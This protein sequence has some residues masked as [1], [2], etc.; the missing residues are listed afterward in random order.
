MCQTP[1]KE[2][3]DMEAP[4]L[5]LMMSTLEKNLWRRNYGARA[6]IAVPPVA[7][8]GSNDAWEIHD[9][10]FFLQPHGISR[11]DGITRM[12]IKCFIK[13]PV[14]KTE[15]SI[16]HFGT[17]QNGNPALAFKCTLVYPR[18]C[19]SSTE[20]YRCIITTTMCIF[21]KKPSINIIAQL[22]HAHE[23]NTTGAS[24]THVVQ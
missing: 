10:Y 14:A 6:V 4:T 5:W 18:P 20:Y 23:P 17:A 19:V 21:N 11:Q 15:T 2:E 3:H 1:D 22:T 9:N 12:L 24:H 7:P 13:I 8:I 16:S